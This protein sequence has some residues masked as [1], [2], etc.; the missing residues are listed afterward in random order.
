MAVARPACPAVWYAPTIR[1]ATVLRWWLTRAML[2]HALMASEACTPTESPMDAGDLFFA[3]VHYRALPSGIAQKELVRRQRHGLADVL[4]VI[5][6]GQGGRHRAS[7]L[8]PRAGEDGLAE[9]AD[10][11]VAAL[12]FAQLAIQQAMLVQELGQHRANP[13]LAAVA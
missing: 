8:L 1:L 7:R 13:R 10:P 4:G 5:S 11:A 2:R 12:A 3:V 6:L 9:F